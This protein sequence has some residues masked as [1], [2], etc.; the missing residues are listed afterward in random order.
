MASA[1]STGLVRSY[2]V[3]SAALTPASASISTP[4]R[5]SSAHSQYTRMAWRSGTGTQRTRTSSSEMGWHNGISCEAILAPCRP[6]ISAITSASP[7]GRRR[8][9]T[10]AN[11]AAPARNSPT[12]TA[13]RRVGRLL[14]ISAM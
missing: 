5:A 9:T 12:A 3:S 13:R 6:A 7:L 2:S 1:G 10:V 11:A 8:S 4:V 14:R